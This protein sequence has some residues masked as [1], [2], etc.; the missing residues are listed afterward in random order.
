MGQYFIIVN[1][2]KKEYFKPNLLKL[3]EICANNDCRVLPYLLATNNPDG[4]II[5]RS[6]DLPPEEAKKKCEEETEYECV[7]EYHSKQWGYTIVR[8]KLKYFGRW[9]GDRV[10]VV[11]DYSDG[12]TN[13]EGPSYEYIRD[14]F[15]DIT[16]EVIKEFNWFIRADE[17]KIKDSKFMNPDIVVTANK[18]YERPFI[19]K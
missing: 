9:C 5:M 18:A 4:T 6:Y 3:W 14:N 11:G 12:A 10:A 2:D 19:P 13:Y 1:L 8:P 17:L 15:K 7:V 16:E